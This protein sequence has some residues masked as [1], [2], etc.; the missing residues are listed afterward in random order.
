MSIKKAPAKRKK[1]PLLE[2][3]QRAGSKGVMVGANTELLID[4]KPVRNAKSVKFEVSAMGVA[5]ATIT[6]VGRFKVAGKIKTNKVKL[7]K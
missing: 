3:R 2:I 5:T 4:G 6:L 7:Y 1:L